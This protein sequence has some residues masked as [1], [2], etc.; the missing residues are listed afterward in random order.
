MAC[1]KFTPVIP[2]MNTVV[3][4]WLWS[5]GGNAYV[6]GVDFKAHIRAPETNAEECTSLLMYMWFPKEVTSLCDPCDSDCCRSDAVSFEIDG[7]T[8]FYYVKQIQPRFLGYPNYHRQAVLC[9]ACTCDGSGSTPPS[10][11]PDPPPSPET[12]GHPPSAKALCGNSVTV[13]SDN[14]PN[15]G[16]TVT[17]DTT[18]KNWINVP[19]PGVNVFLYFVSGGVASLAG[20]S[21]VTP[22]LTDVFGNASWTMIESVSQTDE[23]HLVLNSGTADEVDCIVGTIVW[24]GG[25]GGG[26]FGEKHPTW[27]IDTPFLETVTN[28]TCN[29][30][31]TALQTLTAF[32]FANFDPWVDGDSAGSDAFFTGTCMVTSPNWVW[33][34]AA[35]VHTLNFDH[36]TAIYTSPHAIGFEQSAPADQTFTL[37]SSTSKCSSWPSTMTMFAI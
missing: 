3:T 21:P 19:L 26:P 12:P 1:C 27:R 29:E 9:R 15:L 30:C 33:T 32:D 5:C 14:A 13:I 10:V 23:M 18:A 31:E 6:R 16:D 22:Q 35:G 37:L 24:G 28:G 36:G 7:R 17:I 11:P 4:P 25:G 34:F 2:S 20:L 8:V